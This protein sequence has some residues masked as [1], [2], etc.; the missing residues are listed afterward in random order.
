MFRVKCPICHGTL[1]IDER[2]RRVIGHTT[3]Q[4][5]EKKPEERFESAI[6]K[7]EKAKSE[8]ELRLEE[9]RR[10]E[11]D[12]QKRLEDLFKKAQDKARDDPDAEKPRGPVWD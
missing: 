5:A 7:V 1:T 10:R 2:L 11:S 9:A 6:G 3:E 4:D 8:Q 12:R